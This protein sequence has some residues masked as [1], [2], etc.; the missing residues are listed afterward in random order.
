MTFTSRLA[1]VALTSLLATGT[2]FA[3]TAAPAAKTDAKTTTAAAPAADKKAPKERSAESLE[4]SKQAD[5]KALKGKE[6]KKFR[7]ECMKEAKAGT[8]APA[9]PAAPAADKK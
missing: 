5:A 2:A 8:A 6:R 9:A 3:Q 7:R 1:I 4:C